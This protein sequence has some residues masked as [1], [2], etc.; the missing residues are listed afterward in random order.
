MLSSKKTAINLT[1]QIKL[2]MQ[3]LP[4][5]LIVLGLFA[6]IHGF[7]QP[8]LASEATLK[9]DLARLQGKWKATV[10]TAD[11]SSTWTLGVTGSKSTLRI[12]TQSGDV[13]FKAELDF[14]LEQHGSFR[15]YTYSNLKN[16][17]GDRER[18]PVLTDGKTKSSLYK[19]TSTEFTTIGGF[20][21]DDDDKPLLIKWE[22][23][24]EAKK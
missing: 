23:V 18:E 24:S 8:A 20:R 6:L 17:T 5:L 2:N 21:E 22:K 3:P 10:T 15:A 19:V 7:T 12:A 13:V 1:N 4:R 11:G 16:L 14:K 9:D